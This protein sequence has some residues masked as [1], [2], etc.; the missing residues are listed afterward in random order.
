MGFF[1]PSKK[2]TWTRFAAE[3]GA[4][5]Q[6]GGTWA[7]DTFRYHYKNWDFDF[8]TFTQRHGQTTCIYTRLRVPFL[9]KGNLRLSIYKEGFFSSIG[10]LFN[11]Q[12]IQIN[13]HNFDHSFIIKGNDE[14]KIKQLLSN[15]SLKRAFL[16][17]EGANIRID[18]GRGFFK[19]RYPEDVNA[20]VFECNGIIKKLDK[21]HA[22]FNLFQEVLDSLV[23]IQSIETTNPTYSFHKES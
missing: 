5:Y 18:N 22:L 10:K 1:G 4:H 23:R 3:I 7:K 6:D 8:H 11:M 12:D 13:D 21:L 17:L 2:E 19:D 15:L 20:L 9:V 14:A 16:A